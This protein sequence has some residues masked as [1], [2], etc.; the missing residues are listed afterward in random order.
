MLECGETALSYIIGKIEKKYTI[1]K[2]LS[3][4]N[5]PI[6]LIIT[7]NIFIPLLWI[8]PAETFSLA[9][10][11]VWTKMFSETILARTK[12]LKAIII[13]TSSVTVNKFCSNH[14]MECHRRVERIETNVYSLPPKSVHEILLNLKDSNKTACIVL[15]HLFKMIMYLDI[16]RKEL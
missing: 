14:A 13:L 4:T 10:K 3:N 6:N 7:I 1:L 11:D 8:Y 15:F 2:H 16:I 12:N 5:Q 9:S